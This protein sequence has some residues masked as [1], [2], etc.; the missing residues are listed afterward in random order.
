MITGEQIG[1]HQGL[2]S[3]TIGQGARVSGMPEKMF[4]VRKDVNTKTVYVVPG[5]YAAQPLPCPF[6]EDS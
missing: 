3:Y 4:V 2:W 1:K 6:A 5:T